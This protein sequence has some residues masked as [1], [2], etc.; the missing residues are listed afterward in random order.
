MVNCMVRWMQ[1][2]FFN[3]YFNHLA[4]GIWDLNPKDKGWTQKQI[5]IKYGFIEFKMTAQNTRSVQQQNC[6]LQSCNQAEKFRKNYQ[7]QAVWFGWGILECF[8]QISPPDCNLE[9]WSFFCSLRVF[10][11]VILNTINWLAVIG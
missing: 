9:L 4:T 8:S 3:F 11:A 6:S 7:N 2:S 1:D 10:Y 5:D